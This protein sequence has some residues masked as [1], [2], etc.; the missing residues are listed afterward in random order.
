MGEEGGGGVG[1]EAV[2]VV[3]VVVWWFKGLKERPLKGTLGVI[4]F[5][6]WV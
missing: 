6:V 3:V 5:R 1:R 2:V 4:G